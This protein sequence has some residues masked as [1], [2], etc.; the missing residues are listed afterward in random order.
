MKQ[1]DCYD[2]SASGYHRNSWRK[3]YRP[4]LTVKRAREIIAAAQANAKPESRCPINS[5]LSIQQSIEILSH[6]TEDGI[7]ETTKLSTL[8]ARNIVRA[9][10][11][12]LKTP[13]ERPQTPA[14]QASGRVVNEE[15]TEWRGEEPKG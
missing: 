8:H 10:G 1:S 6:G 5:S 14:L 7:D 11:R 2:A 4:T 13:T 12:Y 15:G 9:L 3:W